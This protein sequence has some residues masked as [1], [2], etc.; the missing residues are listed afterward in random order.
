MDVEIVK[1]ISDLIAIP[2]GGLVSYKTVYVE[3]YYKPGDGGGSMFMYVKDSMDVPNYGIYFKPDDLITEEGR[4]IRQYDGHINA[5]YFGIRKYQTGDWGPAFPDNN[6]ARFQNAIDYSFYT[7]EY[8][9]YNT[10]PGDLTIYFPAGS[11]WF[12]KTLMLKNHTHIK[13]DNGT[14]FNLRFKYANDRIADGLNDYLFETDIGS[15]NRL[16]IENF[17]MNLGA[18]FGNDIEAGGFH[19]KAQYPH[20][21]P[22]HDRSGGVSFAVIKDLKLFSM[23]GHGFWL[24]GQDFSDHEHPPGT[25]VNQYIYF[26][27]VDIERENKNEPIAH[28]THCLLMTGEQVNLSFMG[29]GFGM[30]YNHVPPD[31]YAPMPG[32]HVKITAATARAINNNCSINFVNCHTGGSPGL[33]AQNAFF[34][35]NS[36]NIT[37]DTCWFEDTFTAI[38]IVNSDTINILN[39]RFAN[40]SGQGSAHDDSDHKGECISIREK[41]FVNVMNNY[42]IVSDPKKEYVWTEEYFIRASGSNVINA[43]NN[44][45]DHI[46]LSKTEGITQT[47]IITDVE[48][49][50]LPPVPFAM[51]GIEIWGKKIVLVEAIGEYSNLYRINSS[52]NAGET[53]FLKVLNNPVKLFCCHPSS[54]TQG[55]NVYIPGVA[56]HTSITVNAGQGVTLMKLD[57]PSG[58]ETCIYQVTSIY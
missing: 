32:S 26:D 19:F 9:F 47:A 36:D 41:S 29:C 4:W 1:T 8:P 14:M 6:S 16:Y 37:F 30:A 28:P 34:I 18:G 20:E 5:M 33:A 13:G 2:S 10:D 21:D 31:P 54:E 3:G 43:E 27:N 42:I 25:L 40:A 52:L 48:T 11:Y 38:D 49:F 46:M 22:K 7:N 55:Y 35:E 12:E 44:N 51:P 15:I 58:N 53:L 57:T 56:T 17:Q 50:Y 24:E 39:S 45:F 23:K